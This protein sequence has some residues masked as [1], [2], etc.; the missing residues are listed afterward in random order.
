MPPDLPPASEAQRSDLAGIV[1]IGI[2]SARNSWLRRA[3]RPLASLLSVLQV[4]AAQ[5][6]VRGFAEKL[7]DL[8][9]EPTHAV[10]VVPERFAGVTSAGADMA[11]FLEAAQSLVDLEMAVITQLDDAARV[12]E[13][14][15]ISDEDAVI[16]YVRV[17]SPGCCPRC[18]ILAGR[19]YRWSTGFLRHP[20]C[21]CSMVPVTSRAMA[22]ELAE[23]PMELW[24]DGRIRGLTQA[25]DRALEEG[26]DLSQLVNVRRRAA[27]LTVAG[28]V[29]DR[30][31]RLTPEGIFQLASDR[32]EARRLL[33][34]FGYL[35][36]TIP[37]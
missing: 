23:D 35:T 5:L 20:Q 14:T 25:E 28:R 22:D 18:A 29:I 7:E 17:V 9:V 16:G 10:R 37:T 3:I 33:V 21:R 19:F 36:G 4:E 15:A 12:A 1:A 27:G 13:L 11:R 31:E 8:E 2:A 6:G 24:R 34:R 26:A 30:L 32:D